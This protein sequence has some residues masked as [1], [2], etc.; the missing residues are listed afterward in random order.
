MTY[1]EEADQKSLVKISNYKVGNGLLFPFEFQLLS[2]WIPCRSFLL[3]DKAGSIRGQHGHKNC[4][5]AFWLV[6][7]RI[8]IILRQKGNIL[9][10]L[11]E[12]PEIILSVREK[13]WVEIEFLDDSQVIVFASE[14]YDA[15]DYLYKLEDF[16]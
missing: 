6:N 2:D 16:Q 15:N 11:L 13:T 5:Q 4:K 1:S 12:T 8:R 3:I 14:P 9:E 7:G 10:K